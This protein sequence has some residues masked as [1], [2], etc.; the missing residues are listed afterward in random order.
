MERISFYGAMICVALLL[1][2][3]ASA[4]LCKLSYV[5]VTKPNNAM[6]KIKQFFDKTHPLGPFDVPQADTI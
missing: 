6:H 4:N 1:C 5:P 3:K 2:E